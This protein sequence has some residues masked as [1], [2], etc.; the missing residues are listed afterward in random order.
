MLLHK[1][2]LNDSRVRREASALAEAGHEVTVVHLPAERHTDEQWLDG[3]RLVSATPPPWVRAVLPFRAYR[4]AFLASL[5]RRAIEARPDV[6]HAHDAPMLAPGLIATGLTR[7]RLVYDSHELATGVPY[8]ERLW[9]PLVAGLER[10]ALRRCAAV[11]TVSDG[12]AH[13]LSELYRLRRPPI[14]LRNVPEVDARAGRPAGLRGRLGIGTAS[15]VLHQG[16]LAPRRGCEALVEAVATLRDTHVVFLGDPWPGYEGA[17]Q[18]VAEAHG[19]AGRVHF[20]PS[21]PV[22]ELLDHTREADVGVSLLSDDCENHRLAL[23]NKVFEYIAAGVPVVVSELPELRRLITEHGV[24][25]VVDSRDSA[26]L[27]E[28]LES[29]LTDRYARAD[30]LERAA[31]RLSWAEEKHRLVEAYSGLGGVMPRALVLVRNTV[32]YDARIHREARLLEDLGY[33]T[34]IVGV[35]SASREARQETLGGVRV[36]RLAPGHLPPWLDRRR[37]ASQTTA[38]AASEERPVVQAASSRFARLRR[39]AVT[40]DWYQRCIREVRR[41]RPELVHCN[42]YNTMWAGIAARVLTGSAVVY[43]SHELWPDRNLRPEWRPWLLVCEFFFCR[44]AHECVVTSPGH[45]AVMRGRYRIRAPTV[46][47]NLPDWPDTEAGGGTRSGDGSTGFRAVYFGGITRNRGLEQALEAL[48][49]LPDVSLRLVGPARAD[50]RA[51]VEDA[52]GRLGVRDRVEFDEP[53]PPSE[54]PLVLRDADVGLALFQPTCLSYR[55]GLPN[56]LAEYAAAGVPQVSSNLPVMADFVETHRVGVLADP[57][58][59]RDIAA[60]VRRSLVPERNAAMREAALRSAD[61]FRWPS[62]RARLRAVYSRALGAARVA[63]TW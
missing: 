35:V 27:A 25:S 56:K 54:A 40:V 55:L 30:A 7:A 11:I 51:Q 33:D 1:P 48:T 18:R 60:A 24:G 37:P 10:I 34:R 57:S 26:A 2:V 32:T 52:A 22:E 41:S 53:V 13:R 14:V 45:A 46:I 8:R 62:E 17:I 63:T 3:F 31:A 12:I 21:V 44:A 47:R 6:V 61:Q 29:E 59:P 28:A 42:D 36:T 49:E 23:P 58:D 9:R 39:T 5:V 4:V 43:D 16:A 19:I 15:L 38:G 50:Y 20:V